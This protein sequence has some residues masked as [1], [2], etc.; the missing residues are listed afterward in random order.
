MEG[1][2]THEGAIYFIPKG[3][4][5]ESG[6]KGRDY[7]NRIRDVIDRI[8]EK[9]N[10]DEKRV[11]A[12]YLEEMMVLDD[13]EEDYEVVPRSTRRRNLPRRM[14]SERR[15]GR[16]DLSW[17]EGGST[18]PKA[19]SRVGSEYQAVNLPPAGTFLR[20]SESGVSDGAKE[21]L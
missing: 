3:V 18:F 12:A 5:M 21:I 20:E 14:P 4:D 2:G 8:L 15:A 17:K 19:C 16:V 6:K 10:E 11:A 1:T 13:E 9:R 7:Y